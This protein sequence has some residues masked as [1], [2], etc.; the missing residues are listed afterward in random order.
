MLNFIQDQNRK[1]FGQFSLL[2]FICKMPIALL[3]ELGQP[4]K[5][6]ASGY[7]NY[8]L[9]EIR[10]R[11]WSQAFEF[12]SPK[13]LMAFVVFTGIGLLLLAFW[14]DPL[15]VIS[16]FAFLLGICLV[17]DFF[18]WIS[19]FVYYTIEQEEIKFYSDNPNALVVIDDIKDSNLMD[20]LKKKKQER[21]EAEAE[22][23]RRVNEHYAGRGEYSLDG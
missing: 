17:T 1:G 21:A 3:W 9:R 14:C 5:F 10:S 22:K 7:N 2:R 11:Y 4:F 8:T 20:I 23:V 15:V 16:I 18:L 13:V 19:R 12:Y 6:D